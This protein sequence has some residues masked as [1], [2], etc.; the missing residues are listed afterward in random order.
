MIMK[1]SVDDTGRIQLPDE[2][3][4]QWGVKPGDELA[5]EEQNGRWFLEPAR[6]SP[7]EP[8]QSSGSPD[9][10]D[11]TMPRGL[12]P[13]VSSAGKADH[14]DLNWEDL[15]YESPSLPRPGQVRLRIQRRGKLQPIPHDLE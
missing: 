12:L 5:W 14:D 10:P 13:N 6:S 15:D 3:R 4:A 9:T 8:E 2:V 11:A 7:I 1:T